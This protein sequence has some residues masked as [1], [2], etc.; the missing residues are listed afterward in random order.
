[1]QPCAL[2]GAAASLRHGLWEWSP[3][4]C[5]VC[6]TA[7]A[8]ALLSLP[9]S[10]LQRLQELNLFSCP[11]T[12]AAAALQPCKALRR[13]VLGTRHYAVPSRRATMDGGP[14]PAGSF[15]AAYED[16]EASRWEAAYLDS[17]RAALPWVADVG[18]RH[19]AQLA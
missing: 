19:S 1:M 18:A 13:L 17:V 8:P 5:A 16:E 6:L 10:K 4:G 9:C 11:A 3:P 7:F 15:G 14:M 12:N 2:H